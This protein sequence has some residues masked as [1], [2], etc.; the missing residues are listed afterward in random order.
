MRGAVEKLTQMLAGLTDFQEATVESVVAQFRKQTA[1]RLLVA[2]EVGLGKTVVARGVIA[3]LLID[4]LKANPRG[5]LRVVYV[6]SNRAL[7]LENVRKLAVFNS[8]D[9]K[10]W[11]RLPSFNRLA[12]LGLARSGDHRDTGHLLEICAIT[13]G[14]SL[15]LNQGHGDALER[16]I[17]WQ[18]LKR[19]RY[20]KAD[21]ALEAFFSKDVK[22]WADVGN[23]VERKALHLVKGSL[24]RFRQSISG[25]PMLPKRLG[26]ALLGTEVNLSSWRTLLAS[27]IALHARGVSSRA[28]VDLIS[29]MRA[30]VRALF[31]EACV[32]NLQA[33]LFILDEFQRFKELLDPDPSEEAGQREDQAIARKVLHRDGDHHT[34]LLSATPFKALTHVGEDETGAAH[35]VELQKLFG[36]LTRSDAKFA[37]TY[38]SLREKL[39]AQLLQI[40]QSP[41]ESNSLD[42]S[43][44]RHLQTLLRRVV[45]R[46][47]RD[48]LLAEERVT[49]Q[50]TSHARLLPTLSEIRE[51][52]VLDRIGEA[53][54]AVSEHPVGID[55]LQ[56]FKNAPYALS[57]S[58]PYA[59]RELLQ[60]YRG[61]EPVASALAASER[62]WIPVEK[63]NGYA[64][65]LT[66][67]PASARFGELLEAALPAGVE[68]LLW[69]PP[70][71]SYYK[72]EGAFARTS[73]FSKTLLFSG[74]V[75]APRAL[76]SLVSYECERRLL[77]RTRKSRR[78]Y[79]EDRAQGHGP[80]AFG[81]NSISAAFGLV[82][83]SL[84]LAEVVEFKLGE[85]LAEL[86]AR[87]RRS[88]DSELKEL[89]TTYG[90]VKKKRGVRWYV[91][92]PF[93]LDAPEAR[94]A[95]FDQVEGSKQIAAARQYD[96]RQI[97][98]WLDDSE[99]DLGPPPDDLVD[100]LVDLAI[101]G[102][103]V[104]ALRALRTPAPSQSEREG[105][106]A[107]ACAFSFL[108]RMNRW[109]SQRAIEVSCSKLKPWIALPRYS[110]QGNLQAT[111][112]EYFHLLRGQGNS[113]DELVE[114]FTQALSVG[115]SSVVAQTHLPPRSG[116]TKKFDCSFHCHVAVPLG[117]QNITD[118]K[119]VS[120]VV[121][122]RAAFNS[123]FWPFLLNST[124]VGQE[125]LDFHWYCRRVV[126]WSLP[127]NPIDIEQ[128]EGRVNRY[129]S[130]LVRQRLVKFVEPPSQVIHPVD[131]WGTLFSQAA[132]R[133]MSGTDLEPLWHVN[134]NSPTLERV[135]PSVGFGAEQ[136]RL[137]QLLRVLSLYRLCFGQPR[138]EELLASLLK[139]EYSVDDIREIKRALIIELA[140]ILH[141]Q[142]RY[143]C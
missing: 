101:A 13:P 34:L 73:Q 5:P 125:G 92:A 17:V 133:R 128:R 70:S 3:R 137:P 136:A 78:R 57:F 23:D 46:T 67:E 100:Y 111:F 18:A 31:V 119:G 132:A 6:C 140:P 58:G 95:W 69:V 32:D 19:D 62:A 79:F 131:L 40:P 75:I 109:E 102:P 44:K 96:A 26:A 114:A 84:R 24:D 49:L 110:A 43:S 112:D 121:N 21:D 7:A 139:H 108:T 103:A 105:E 80:L 1:A 141:M 88:L 45:F 120:R 50:D 135:V 134:C 107:T 51:H 10:R 41:I 74:L 37:S 83:P 56:L 20:V 124:S 59:V 115:A 29:F 36:Y 76:S 4:R 14:T 22:R 12:E 99:L 54:K 123:P 127:A 143:D 35:A 11:M 65:D 25:A 68:E 97:A 60:T 104:C 63:L 48:Q 113:K 116:D 89:V 130:L 81:T 93:L 9:A 64:L 52:A 27:A 122:V 66:H 38:E 126:H 15:A 90:S 85:S 118:Q 55:M 82:Y 30:K 71:V 28:H 16:Y 8:E 47:E 117:N 87:V 61:V 98:S 138:Q 2:D 106:M 72:A 86:R 42:S 53:L 33:D 142:S 94:Q 77:T 39:L 91:L 129:K